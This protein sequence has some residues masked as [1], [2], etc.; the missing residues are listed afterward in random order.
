MSGFAPLNAPTPTR[1]SDVVFEK[2]A[3]SIISGEFAPGTQLKDDELAT[4]LGVSR[5]PVREAFLR[6]E[7]TGMI[8]MVASRYTRVADL[9]PELVRD[10]FEFA[11]NQAG[12]AALLAVQRMTDD[13]LDAAIGLLDAV[14]AGDSSTSEQ[15]LR[16]D[17]FY[18]QLV[19]HSRSP[20]L[21]LV[22][23]DI[24]LALARAVH[25]VD[26]DVIPEDMRARMDDGYRRLRDALEARDAVAAER[27]VREIH[28]VYAS[29]V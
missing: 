11:G 1:L 25:S 16:A 22:T 21:V 20:H 18:M 2:I 29:A 9:T 17:A 23:R 4:S 14:I 19:A 3:A 7:R 28:A 13:E 27:T 6:L 24:T 12:W 26:F 5:M 10:A 15:R 8:E